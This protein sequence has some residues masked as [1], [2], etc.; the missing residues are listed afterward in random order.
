[1]SIQVEN[2]LNNN[3]NKEL[4]EQPAHYVPCKIQEDGPANVEKYFKTY[5]QEN[6]G[7]TKTFHRLKE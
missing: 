6:G 7:G 2:N 4:F 5:I 3:E 1:M